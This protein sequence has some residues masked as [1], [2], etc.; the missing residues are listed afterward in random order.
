MVLAKRGHNVTLFEKSGHLGGNLIAVSKPEFKQGLKDVLAWYEAEIVKYPNIQIEL[1]T[2]IKSLEDLNAD[3]IIVATGAKT[4]KPKVKGIDRAIPA[5][6]YLTGKQPIYGNNVIVIG[7]GITGCEIA[8]DM[9]EKGFNPTII[10]TK[11][12]LIA[13]KKGEPKADPHSTF[14]RGYLTNH[15]EIY[16][17][18]KLHSVTYD[19]ILA[20]DEEGKFKLKADHVVYALGYEPNPVF[21]LG[22]FEKLFNFKV[23]FIGN[24]NTVG[25]VNDVILDARKICMKI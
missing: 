23:K 10:E 12:A 20:S 14:L 24:A 25:T 7:G 16:L 11:T 15:A 3:K 6:D 13:D 19:G 4:A 9:I 18:T 21:K 5:L 17:D 22:F 2:K 8:Y 1:Y